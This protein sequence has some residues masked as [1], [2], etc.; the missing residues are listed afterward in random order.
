MN[1]TRVA[2]GAVLMAA[3]ITAAA[4]PASATAPNAFD[5]AVQRDLGLS[6]DEAQAR[7]AQQDRAAAIERALSKKLGAAFGGAYFDAAS[8]S[9]VV[10]VTD[11]ASAAAVRAAGA[12]ATLVQYSQRQ[13][14][15]IQA[16][17]A[18]LDAAAGVT[19]WYT[20]VR[21]N[22][23]VV[24]VNRAAATAAT[25]AYLTKAQAVSD[26]VTVAEVSASP[27][28][29]TKPSKPGKPS[30]VAYVRGG[31]AWTTLAW[32]CSVGF[33]ATGATGSKHYVTAGHCTRGAGPVNGYNGKPQGS[34]GGSVFDIRGDY[35]KVDVTSAEWALAGTVNRYG[36]GDL[37][38][39]GSTEAPV[40]AAVC[41]SGSTTGWHCGTIKAK[42]QTVIYIDGMVVMGL[43]HTD[44]CAEPGDSGGSFITG[45]GQ[46]QGMTSGGSGDCK[47]GGET[48]F[49]PVNESLQ[50][51]GLQLVLS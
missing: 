6:A 46:A 28:V 7:F 38:V 36:G 18:T 51:Y 30:A 29:L 25:D 41:R 23:V 37:A 33:S 9:L 24:N 49:Q 19:G 39:K 31:D 34:L 32:R 15:A 1:R 44:A 13:L 48:Y 45:T 27:R 16:K 8:G 20:D 2:I 4:V 11:Q 35:G 26:A 42:N 43:T 10:G 5:A 17:L 14:D 3:G 40:G 12:K 50:A 21:A 47:E 22:R